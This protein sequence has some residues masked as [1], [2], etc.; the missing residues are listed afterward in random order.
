MTYTCLFSL[1]PENY[2][3]EKKDKAT[4]TKRMEKGHPHKI[5]FNTILKDGADGSVETDL[6][7]QWKLHSNAEVSTEIDQL[8]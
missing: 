2:S 5:Y 7:G 1:S 4:R 6:T 3:D 8:P